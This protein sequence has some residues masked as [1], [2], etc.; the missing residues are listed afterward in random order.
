EA[1]R[2]P[3]PA[4]AVL[5]ARVLRQLA[6][7]PERDDHAAGLEE[8]DVVLRR[9]PGY[10]AERLVEAPRTPEVAHAEGDEAH[11]LIHAG[12]FIRRRTSALRACTRRPP[13]RRRAR[14][15]PTPASAGLCRRPR[16]RPRRSRSAP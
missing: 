15:R 1:G 5:D 14:G 13:S 4:A 10:P 7:P 12:I 9:R 16:R 3:A 6:A 11:P 2:D 8:D